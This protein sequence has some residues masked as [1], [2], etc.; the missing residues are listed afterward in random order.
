M[1]TDT[2]I[3][4][5]SLGMFDAR[6]RLRSG[7]WA[8]RMFTP[9]VSALD[10]EGMGGAGAGAGAGAG[11]PTS[12]ADGEVRLKKQF[13]RSVPVSIAAGETRRGATV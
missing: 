12:A 10:D 8:L 5:V 9:D 11:G 1:D 13:V 6:R 3:A 2:V 7:R 4:S